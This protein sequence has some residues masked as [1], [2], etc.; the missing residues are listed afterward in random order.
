MTTTEEYTQ[1]L[2][3]LGKKLEIITRCPECDTPVFKLLKRR[4]A[5]HHFIS[6]YLVIGCEGFQIFNLDGT[7]RS[8]IG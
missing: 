4:D 8:P 2:L 7:L 5:D 6:I 3:K 1:T